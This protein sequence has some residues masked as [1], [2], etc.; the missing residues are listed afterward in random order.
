MEQV[1]YQLPDRDGCVD[2]ERLWGNGD[3]TFLL[4]ATDDY[5]LEVVVCR[6][7]AGNGVFHRAE[8]YWLNDD[9]ELTLQFLTGLFGGCSVHQ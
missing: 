5:N 4:V 2:A 7:M 1:I 9:G 3:V 8:S 6:D